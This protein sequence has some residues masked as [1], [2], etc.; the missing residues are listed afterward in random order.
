MEEVQLESE[1]E[2]HGDYYKAG[3]QLLVDDELPR[4]YALSTRS[5]KVGACM[6]DRW[7][8][9]H[10]ITWRDSGEKELRHQEPTS[11]TSK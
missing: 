1:D 2:H 10:M 11:R 5:K 3:E 8:V 4:I 6:S 9:H 7:E